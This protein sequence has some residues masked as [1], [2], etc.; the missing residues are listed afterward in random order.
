MKMTKDKSM[1]IVKDILNEEKPLSDPELVK[2][3]SPNF[4]STIFVSN[5]SQQSD[6][7]KEDF[8]MV[9]N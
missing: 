6:Q 7:R 2:S 4:I 8:L 1:R 9:A 5:D 3:H